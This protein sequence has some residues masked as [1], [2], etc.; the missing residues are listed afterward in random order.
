[1]CMQFLY[2]LTNQAHAEHDGGQQAYRRRHGDYASQAK[3]NQWILSALVCSQLAMTVINSAGCHQSPPGF[4]PC[5]ASMQLKAAPQSSCPARKCG[6]VCLAAHLSCR[7]AHMVAGRHCS[8]HRLHHVGSLLTL[9]HQT[10][11]AAIHNCCS[12]ALSW[13]ACVQPFQQGCR[14]IDEDPADKPS[15]AVLSYVL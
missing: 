3:Q 4:L 9:D 10:D 7:Q 11:D 1:M 14:Q 2:A 15:Y 13:T 8:S 12:L 6:S 5:Q